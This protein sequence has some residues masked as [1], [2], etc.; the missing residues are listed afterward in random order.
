MD[1][2]IRIDN[3]WTG[4]KPIK[5]REKKIGQREKKHFLDNNNFLE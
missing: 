5:E 4:S 2:F 3:G 1:G